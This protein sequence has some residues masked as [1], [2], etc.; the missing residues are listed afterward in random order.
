MYSS[1]YLKCL[2]IYY[3]IVSELVMDENYFSFLL[4]IKFS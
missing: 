3:K 2:G 1:F 4:F